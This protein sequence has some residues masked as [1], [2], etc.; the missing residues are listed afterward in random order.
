M[1][2]FKVLSNC[3]P[4]TFS[5]CCILPFSIQLRLHPEGPL[6]ALS[7]SG[8]CL[9]CWLFVDGIGQQG[10]AVM[11]SKLVS[12]GVGESQVEDAWEG[13]T[14]VETSTSRRPSQPMFTPLSQHTRT[15][16]SSPSDSEVDMTSSHFQ[17]FGGSHLATL[18]TSHFCYMAI[19]IWRSLFRKRL[20]RNRS[21]YVLS[22]LEDVVYDTFN[23]VGSCY[24]ELRYILV[25][26]TPPVVA[27]RW[28]YCECRTKYCGQ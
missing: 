15:Q 12:R 20:T 24:W 8:C 13:Q 6:E 1:F 3:Q 16:S 14:G 22:C 10:V 28:S 27:C 21:T 9:S 23:F 2:L 7:C 25:S 17:S 18:M 11:T 4:V 26:L 19:C 5:S